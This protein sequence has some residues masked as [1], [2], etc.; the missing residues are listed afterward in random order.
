[1]KNLY[2]IRLI[3]AFLIII[4]AVIASAGYFYPIKIFDLQVAALIQ[5][6][7]VNISIATIVYLIFV[8]ALT[9]ASG[10]LYC[11]LFCPL[12]I[13]QETINILTKKKN[14]KIK[15]FPFKYLLAITAFTALIF[16]SAYILRYLE[17]YT[18]FVSAIS[19]S[20]TGLILISAILIITAFKGRFF[21]TNICP[22]GTI[23]GILSKYSIFKI[24]IDKENCISC[25][26]C[27]KNCQAGCIDAKEKTVDNETCI[28]C[29]KCL[30]LCPKNA[31]KYTKITRQPEVFSIKRRKLLIAGTLALMTGAAVTARLNLIKT[32]KKI[33]NMILPP[34]ALNL[35][36][37]QK[38]CFNCNL[39]VQQCPQKII[40]KAD[41]NFN[42][43]HIEY[44]DFGHCEY[45]CHNCGDVCPTGAV[46]RITLE[47][48]QKTR[49]AMAVIDKEKC[50]N[51]GACKLQCPKKT[52]VSKDN[53]FEI[54]GTGCIGCGICQAA[55][56]ANAITMFAIKEQKVI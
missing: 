16:G 31:V 13:L 23:L 2:Q 55:C 46:K 50:I 24:S 56:P 40:K 51:C 29:L 7:L 42:A 27:E 36:E 11:S 30:N 35:D 19:F 41:K 10:R 34:G 17:P 6:I 3:S 18:I 32:A 21:C 48:K 8:I 43:P 37:F 25:G 22:T 45:N 52:I 38:K 49:I 26:N 14:E 15:N 4:T 53:T 28:K 47:E 9:A 54:N 39:C 44:G 33:K 5:K 20:T 1:M 12:G